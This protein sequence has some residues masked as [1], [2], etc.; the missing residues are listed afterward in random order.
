MVRYAPI[1][2]YV[3]MNVD[4]EKV[5]GSFQRTGIQAE[6]CARYVHIAHRGY[7]FFAAERGNRVPGL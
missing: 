7:Y 2:G 6:M 5:V 1:H 4:E 3:S